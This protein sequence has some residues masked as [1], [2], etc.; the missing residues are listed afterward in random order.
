M[1]L[2]DGTL[3]QTDVIGGQTYYT[4]LALSCE[5]IDDNSNHPVVLN[6]Y[7][8]SDSACSNCS[9]TALTSGWQSKED[10]AMLL[11]EDTAENCQAWKTVESNN[12]DQLN[13][14]NLETMLIDNSDSSLRSGP[15]DQVTA[16]AKVYIG[17]T[18]LSD[19]IPI[20]GPS[21][22]AGSNV[23]GGT[24][25]GGSSAASNVWGVSLSM[26]AVAGLSAAILSV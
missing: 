17:N 1:A 18:C 21:P 5:H 10:I 25:A 23:F 24:E 15:A 6:G 2:P 9:D 3:C 13:N 11:N 7:L 8:C 19:Y 12:L 26:F 16:F 14:T 22:T 20:E 4:K